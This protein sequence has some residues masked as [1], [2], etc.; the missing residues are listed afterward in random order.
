MAVWQP[1][2]FLGNSAFLCVRIGL[3][4]LC[5]Y[6]LPELI[7]HHLQKAVE[8]QLPRT[9]S[10]Q[11]CLHQLQLGLYF[12]GLWTFSLETWSPS[13][14][15]LVSWWMLVSILFL[16]ASMPAVP[17]ENIIHWKPKQLISHLILYADKPFRHSVDDKVVDVRCCFR[18]F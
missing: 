13:V 12:H 4:C 17:I 3:F 18:S 9:L 15:F 16:K 5:S 14:S 6:T 1:V 2:V 10:Y 8:A 11:L 7:G